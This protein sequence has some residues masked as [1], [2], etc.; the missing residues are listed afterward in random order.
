MISFDLDM[1]SLQR[2]SKLVHSESFGVCR[3]PAQDAEIARD[4]FI[5][6]HRNST[7][8]PFLS[9]EP[10]APAQYPKSLKVE[11]NPYEEC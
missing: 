10:Q 2:R 4:F 3:T 7:L 9:F 5:S 11:N 8:C 6:S 1:N